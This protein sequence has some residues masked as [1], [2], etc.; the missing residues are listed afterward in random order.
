MSPNE[1]I[2]NPQSFTPDVFIN[3]NSAMDMPMAQFPLLVSAK[4]EAER[5]RIILP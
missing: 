4:I 1:I 3:V 2:S 5:L